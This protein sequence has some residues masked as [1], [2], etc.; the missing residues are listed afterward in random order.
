MSPL[1]EERRWWRVVPRVVVAGGLPGAREV[2][3]LTGWSLCLW[4][5]PSVNTGDYNVLHSVW[6]LSVVLVLWPG[7]RSCNCHLDCGL[8]LNLASRADVC[9]REA[10]RYR[11]GRLVFPLMLGLPDVCATSLVSSKNQ[12]WNRNFDNLFGVSWPRPQ[13]FPDFFLHCTR[14]QRYSRPLEFFL[15]V[16]LS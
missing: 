14:A 11:S 13:R 3:R 5:A 8:G 2:V 7:P 12:S 1:I 9:E 6:V 4:V 10:R 16:P 15:S